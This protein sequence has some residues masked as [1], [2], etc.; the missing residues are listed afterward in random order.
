MAVIKDEKKRREYYRKYMAKRR[1]RQPKERKSDYNPWIYC[2]DIETSTTTGTNYKGKEVPVSFIISFASS[3]LNTDSG[4]IVHDYFGR[5][6]SDLDNYLYRLKKESKELKTL[7]YIHFF[8]YEFSFFKDNLSF[9]KE[10]TDKQLFIKPH[11]PLV[12]N[13]KNLS[14]RCSNLLLAKSV[15][16]LGEELSKRTGEDWHKL[17]YD[18]KKVRTPLSK[19]SKKEKEYNLRDCDIVVKYIYEVLLKKY[20]LKELF[21]NLYTKTGLTRLDNKKNNSRNDY[22]KWIVF[23]NLCRPVN[24]KQYRLEELSFMGGFVSSNP[25]YCGV[26]VEDAGSDDEISAYPGMM[27]LKFPYFFRPKEEL[28]NIAAF[29]EFKELRFFNIKKF[30]YAHIAIKNV[31]IKPELNYPIWSKHKTYNSLDLIDI[32]G[33][34]IKADYMEVV[35]T[36]RKSVV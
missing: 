14:F 5:S 11:K 7:I 20:S 29:K 35:L 32:N 36:D 6:Y 15:K 22:Q 28:K 2:I 3:K 8:G 27:M 30:F 18:Y 25:N 17:D 26:V 24:E 13:C 12:I 10:E 16:K 21:D 23:N 33:K 9:F 1:K 31:N 4:E 34:V 19:I